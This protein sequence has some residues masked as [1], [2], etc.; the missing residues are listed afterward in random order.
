LQQIKSPTIWNKDIL[1][2]KDYE[3]FTR[4]HLKELVRLRFLP[5]DFPVGFLASIQ[6]LSG[7]DLLEINKNA[8]EIEKELSSNNLTIQDFESW[9][10]FDMIFDFY[11]LKNADELAIPEIGV[12]R[13]KQYQMVCKQLEKSNN[14]QFVLWSKIVMKTMNGKPSNHFKINL[15][16]NQIDRMNP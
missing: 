3:D 11:R 13:L 5:E 12:N 16:T 1:K 8:P 7:K 15:K 6:K 4:W 2:A 10:G 14:E 9:T